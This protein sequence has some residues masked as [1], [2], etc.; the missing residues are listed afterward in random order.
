MISWSP[1]LACQYRGTGAVG[2]VCIASARTTRPEM[3]SVWPNLGHQEDLVSAR[4]D[5]PTRDSSTISLKITESE[6]HWSSEFTPMFLIP[7]LLAFLLPN[8]SNTEARPKSYAAWA[9][10]SGVARSQGNGHGL[11]AGTPLVAY[12]DGEFQWSFRLL[13]D[14]IQAGANNVVLPKSTVTGGYNQLDPLRTGLTFVYLYEQTQEAKCKTAAMI[15]SSQ[16]NSHPRAAQGQFW[17]TL[18]YFNQGGRESLS[19]FDGICMGEVFYAASTNEFESNNAT[20]WAGI[21]SQCKLMFENM[22]Q[23]A[24]APNNRVAVFYVHDGSLDGYDYSHTAVWASPDREMAP[25]NSN[26]RFCTSSTSWRRPTLRDAADP[27]TGVWWLSSGVVTY[28]CA[29]LKAARLGFVADAD[30]GVVTAKRAYDDGT[31]DWKNTVGV[32][33]SYFIMLPDGYYFS[34]SVELNDL[35]GVLASLEYERL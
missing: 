35:K 2:G 5:D 6:F 10:D 25:A 20:A 21:T 15:Y 7:L 23:N 24:T 16:L 13:F 1:V 30:G 8:S 27:A 34:Q 33:A 17:H 18:E 19:R 28:I 22:L 32:G 12:A 3:R 14:Y 26:R 29:L 31:M 4:F 11:D 9:A